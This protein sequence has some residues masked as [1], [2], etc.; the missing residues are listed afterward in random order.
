MDARAHDAAAFADCAE[1]ERHQRADG[2]IDNRAIEFDGRFSLRAAC[3]LRAE[4]SSKSLR[5][6]VTGPGKDEYVA[7]L[8]DCDLGYDVG[9]GAEAVE[10]YPLSLAGD[11]QRAPTY[12]AGAEKGGGR[13]IIASLGKRKNEFGIGHGVGGKAAIGRVPGEQRSVAKIFFA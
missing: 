8:P 11:L 5:G 2:S 6:R 7:A 3:P 10:P 13:Y 12:Q 1:R 4:L 9:G